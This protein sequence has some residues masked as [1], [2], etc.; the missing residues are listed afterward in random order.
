VLYLNKKKKIIK[1]QK[2]FSLEFYRNESH[3]LNEL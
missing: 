3:V 1:K 2:T